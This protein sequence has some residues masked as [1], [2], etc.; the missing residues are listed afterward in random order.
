MPT[1]IPKDDADWHR[2]AKA[3]LEAAGDQPERVRTI[4]PRGRLAFVVDD[5]LAAAVGTGDYTPEADDDPEPKPAKAPSKRAVRKTAA[6][7][8]Q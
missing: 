3:L 8:A 2:L 5:D 4:N 1:I 6:K 7:T